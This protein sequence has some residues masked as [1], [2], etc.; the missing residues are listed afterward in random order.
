MKPVLTE[1]FVH[2]LTSEIKQKLD[3]GEDLIGTGI[4]VTVLLKI[5]EE[6]L[7]IVNQDIAGGTFTDEPVGEAEDTE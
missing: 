3:G 7:E 6:G 4:Q 5:K 2:A 1:E